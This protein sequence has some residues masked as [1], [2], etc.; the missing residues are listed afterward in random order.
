MDKFQN[1][2][3]RKKCKFQIMYMMQFKLRHTENHK[4]NHYFDFYNLLYNSTMCDILVSFIWVH[5]T[6]FWFFIFEVLYYK[7][8]YEVKVSCKPAY[9][10]WYWLQIVP[11]E[12]VS[13]THVLLQFLKF[14]HTFINS[15][16]WKNKVL[17][18]EYT[19]SWDDL[20]QV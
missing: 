7:R 1:Q 20:H 13:H 18:G 8:N 10:G 11:Q 9:N 16:T 3:M 14:W 17:L 4:N 15:F 19:L 12:S 6:C 2:Y 5:V